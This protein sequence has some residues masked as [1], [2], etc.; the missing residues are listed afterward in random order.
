VYTINNSAFK[1]ITLCGLIIAVEII[2]N[3][4]KPNVTPENTM[5]VANP[6][7]FGK[8]SQLIIAGRVNSI[9]FPMP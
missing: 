8:Y 3:K 9:P 2:L 7:L 1:C 6:L 4:Q 5:P